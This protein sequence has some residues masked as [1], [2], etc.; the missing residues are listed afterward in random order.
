MTT[1]LQET[2]GES[3]L[4]ELLIESSSDGIWA[5]DDAC[6]I[7]VWNPAMMQISGLSKNEVLGRPA[8]DVFSC[9]PDPFEETFFEAVFKGESVITGE[10]SYRF[11]DVGRAGSFEVCYS[12][13]RN[14][15]GEIVGGLAVVRDVTARQL[16]SERQRLQAILDTL[17]VCVVIASATGEVVQMNEMAHTIWGPFPKIASISEYRVFKGWKIPSGEPMQ[18]E[19]WGLAR[20]L[21]YGE[22]TV[23]EMIDIERF[24]GERGTIL[25]SAA[26]LLDSMGN[27]IGGIAV[28]QDITEQR[29]LEQV[30]QDQLELTEEARREAESASEDRMKLLA[31]VSH[32]LR[33]PLTTIKGFT[34]TLLAEDVTWDAATQREFL[35]IMDQEADRLTDLIG[36]LLDFSRFNSGTFRITLKLHPTIDIVADAYSALSHLAGDRLQLSLPA[37]LPVLLVDGNR[38]GQVLV[39]LV[40]NA[41]KYAPPETPVIVTAKCVDRWVQF[42]VIDSGPGIPA[43]QRS[44]VFEPFEQLKG[45]DHYAKGLGLGLTICKGIVE[46]HGGRIWVEDTQEGTAIS[47]TVPIASEI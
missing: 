46:A 43:D 44:K 26:P 36:Q 35:S 31:T 24:N 34:S 38:V 25:H 19:D 2:V 27:I 40:D 11:R 7:T 22:T 12:P 6:R 5:F 13:V 41:V 45:N 18:P 16:E 10:R 17:P 28:A 4:T 8:H 47:F 37:D 3:E 15:N 29:I 20:A 42:T 9:A 32:E 1:W 14:R 21:L 33:A 23:S 30:L 39:N